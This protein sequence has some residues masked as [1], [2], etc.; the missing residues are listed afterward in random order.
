MSASD[1]Q[2]SEGGAKRDRL[3]SLDVYRGL[4]VAG[5]ILVTDPGTYSAVYPQL[6]HAVWAGATLTDMIFPSF[7]FITGVAMTL[8]ISGR[9]RRGESRSGLLLHVVR[10]CVLLV[11][12][13]LVLNGFPEF[14]LSTLRLPGILQRIGVCYLSGSLVYLPLREGDA[15]R[16]RR[17]LVL[18]GWVA[19]CWRFIGLC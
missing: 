12:L 8:S 2:L 1:S 14:H 15:D 3:L 6:R 16:R 5:M 17:G 4:T 19:A 18:A 10:R 11:V 13:G 7:L 9:L